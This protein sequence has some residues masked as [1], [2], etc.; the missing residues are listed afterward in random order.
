MTRIAYILTHHT[1]FGKEAAMGA[2]GSASPTKLRNGADPM[3]DWDAWLSEPPEQEP[4]AAARGPA[5][6]DAAAAGA[7]RPVE[8]KPERPPYVL[9]PLPERMAEEVLL[10]LRMMAHIPEQIFD[11][12]RVITSAALDQAQPLDDLEGLLISQM[13]A[14]HSRGMG[15]IRKSLDPDY[16][17]TPLPCAQILA[18][19]RLLSLARRQNYARMRYRDWL[20]ERARREKDLR[21]KPRKKPHKPQAGSR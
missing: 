12:R 10:A 16:L 6:A 13:M 8:P 11:R 3:K 21:R 4:G 18:A 2:K 9:P 5:G 20:E 19:V 1:Y 17:D 7:D 14:A 15:L